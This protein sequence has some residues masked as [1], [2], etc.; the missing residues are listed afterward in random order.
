[1]MMHVLLHYDPEGTQSLHPIFLQGARSV[2]ASGAC[3]K[4]NKNK[5]PNKS[6]NEN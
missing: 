1:M 2:S 6:N 4:Q 3:A 5:K